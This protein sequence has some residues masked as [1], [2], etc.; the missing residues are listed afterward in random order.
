MLAWLIVSICSVVILLGIVIGLFIYNNV[1]DTSGWY[2]GEEATITCGVF[3]FFAVASLI[4][5]CGLYPM[6]NR[7]YTKHVADIMSVSRGSGVEGSFTLGCG[8]VK[9]VQYYFYYYETDKGVKLGKIES[10]KTYVVE[11]DKYTPS[12]YEIKEL[13]TFNEYY[14]LYVPYNTIVTTYVLN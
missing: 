7:E 10:D 12:L 4:M 5:C 3:G 14:N 1:K 6:Y 8:T 2:V 9:D 11:T 13:H